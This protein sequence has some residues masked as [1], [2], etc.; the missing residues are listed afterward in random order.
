[1][2]STEFQP[3][4]AVRL[5]S[6][7]RPMTVAAIDVAGGKVTCIWLSESGES[8]KDAFAPAELLRRLAVG[9]L[10]VLGCGCSG[11]PSPTPYEKGGDGFTCCKALVDSA[12]RI[13]GMHT[14]LFWVLAVAGLLIVAVGA[15]LVHGQADSQEKSHLVVKWF[16]VVSGVLASGCWSAAAYFN[17]RGKDADSA[18]SSAQKLIAQIPRQ[19]DTSYDLGDY[20]AWQDCNLVAASWRGS[21]AEALQGAMDRLN[22]TR[23]EQDRMA[24]GAGEA[25]TQ[26]K[27]AEEKSDR[28]ATEATEAQNEIKDA[29]EQVGK[30]KEA[31]AKAGAP[32]V[33]KQLDDVEKGLQGTEVRVKGIESGSKDVKTD[34]AKASG[35]HP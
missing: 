26:V 15:V 35:A 16:C 29:R 27:A 1:M 23:M 19:G 14:G 18:R 21:H 20:T 13:A 12:D 25:K 10:A 28:L 22:Q 30:A 6:S 17:F 9:L 7:G 8:Q 2:A 32:A 5:R 33:S 3:G 24:Q 4:D 34:A 31:A 11:I